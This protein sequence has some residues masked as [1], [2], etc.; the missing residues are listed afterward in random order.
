MDSDDWNSPTTKLLTLLNVSA[1]KSLKRKC[2]D[3]HLHKPDK[4]R[5]LDHISPNSALGEAN[6]DGTVQ[7]VDSIGEQK[8]DVDAEVNEATEPPDTEESTYEQHFGPAPSFLNQ[9][10]I[11]SVNKCL[12]STSASAFPKIGPVVVSKVTGLPGPEK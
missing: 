4:R 2:A 3:Q 5:V 10:A 12:W 6:A 7:A 1:A 8:D 11:E 9:S